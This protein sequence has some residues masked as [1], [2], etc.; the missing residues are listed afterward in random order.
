MITNREPSVTAKLCILDN[1]E[2]KHTYD[3]ARDEEHHHDPAALLQ[4]VRGA[5][6]QL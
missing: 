6:G 5:T 4:A 2:D 1:T 3:P